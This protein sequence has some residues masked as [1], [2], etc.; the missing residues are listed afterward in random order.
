MGN[1]MDSM[2]KA[3]EIAQNAQTLNKELME[4]FFTGQD[5]TG[6]VVATFNGIGAPVSIKVSDSILS[7]GSEAVSLASS[8]AMVDAHARSQQAMMAKMQGLY[9]GLK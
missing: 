2:K 4:T 8:Q 9:S 5:P 7:Q 1:I 6:Q 3:Q